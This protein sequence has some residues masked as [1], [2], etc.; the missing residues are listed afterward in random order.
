MRVAIDAQIVLRNHARRMIIGAAEV[1][2]CDVILPVT[3]VTMAKTHYDKVARSYVA[4]KTKWDLATQGRELSDEDFAEL[5]ADRLDRVCAGFSRWLDEEPQRNDGAF[6]IAQ[7]TRR[8]R[9]LA[10]ELANANVVIDPKDTRWGVGE[11]P[12]VLAE[13]LEAGAHWV[14]SGNFETLDE[15]NMEEWLDQAQREG[16]YTHVPRPF[17]LKPESAVTTLV[18]QNP[19]FAHA[20]PKDNRQL[21]VT[22]AHAICEPN[23]DDATIDRRIA[24]MGRFATELQECG[25]RTSGNDV[26]NWALT[27]TAHV[28]TNQEHKP[29]RDIERMQNAIGKTRVRQTREGE[30]RRMQAEAKGGTWTTHTPAREGSRGQK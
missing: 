1:G 16:R 11:D 30:D 10:I 7:R 22:L 26:E 27:A 28:K 4:K 25:M 15:D 18:R 17:I 6:R 5:V 12:N 29:W 2:G 8:A 21:R 3:C 23:A 13:T 9:T 20:E 24:I 19:N 14:A